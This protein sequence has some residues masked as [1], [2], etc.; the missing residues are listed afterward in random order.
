MWRT[1]PAW[2]AVD[3]LCIG[4]VRH[5]AFIEVNEARTEAAATTVVIGVPGSALPTATPE[6][7]EMRIDRPFLFCIYDVDTGSILFLGRTMN[8]A[9][10]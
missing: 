2:T 4:D 1:S 5:K 3:E 6:P 9:Q 7:V 8:P 10:R